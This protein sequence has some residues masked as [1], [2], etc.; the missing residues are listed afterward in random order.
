MDASW[1][2]IAFGAADI[3]L[4][5]ALVSRCA[6][7]A[8][9]ALAAALLL[10]FTPSHMAFSRSGTLEGIWPLPFVLGWAACLASLTNRPSPR[11]RWILAAAMTSLLISG[12]GHASA[13]M[14]VPVFGVVAILMFRRADGWRAS[15][16][17][18]AAAVLAATLAIAVLSMVLLLSAVAWQR[19]A[20]V[21]NWFWN[22]FLP[23]HL[24]L[25]P[26]SPGF[27]GMFLAPTVVPMA[28]GVYALIRRDDA[29]GL[30]RLRPMIAAGCI[31]APL[32][33]AIAGPPPLDAHALVVAPF[34]ALLATAGGSLMW[35][36]GRLIGRIVLGGLTA[37]AAFQAFVCLL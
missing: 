17:L 20:T 10:L 23:S 28:I 15:D 22:F 29:S 11:D 33:A 26:G 18:R 32:A 14:M 7:R 37:V 8:D 4:L 19:A 34:A 21:S 27:C 31:G 30:G 9:V 5:F 36:R 35:R 6:G 16:A 2:A 13:A 1:S 25:A 24:F 3:V 12:M